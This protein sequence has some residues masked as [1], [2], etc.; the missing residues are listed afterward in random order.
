MGATFTKCGHRRSDRNTILWRRANG[1]IGAKC[2]SCSNRRQRERRNCEEFRSKLRMQYAT[3][4]RSNFAPLTPNDP[5][6]GTVTGYNSYRCRCADCRAAIATAHRICRLK[7]KA[8]KLGL[9]VP[10]VANT[11][12]SLADYHQEFR[13]GVWDDPVAAAVLRET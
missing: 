12:V 4:L 11:V 10:S 8:R 1:R 13:T 6:H 2:R 9:K 3:R 5:H 7:R